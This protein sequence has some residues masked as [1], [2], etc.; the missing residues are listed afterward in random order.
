M[1]LAFMRWPHQISVVVLFCCCFPV[2]MALTW[3]SAIGLAP[4]ISLQNPDPQ[5]LGRMFQ[6]KA[7]FPSASCLPL[8]SLASAS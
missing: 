6:L 7:C 1:S 8:S 2:S 4:L 5:A 3:A